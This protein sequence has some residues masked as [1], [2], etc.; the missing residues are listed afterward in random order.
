MFYFG[1]NIVSIDVICYSCDESLH[2]GV[3]LD[4]VSSVYPTDWLVAA[5]PE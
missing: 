5:S 4:F 1:F 2:D 3:V